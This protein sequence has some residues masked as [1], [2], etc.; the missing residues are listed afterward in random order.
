MR[1][2]RGTTITGLMAGTCPPLG[3][4]DWIHRIASQSQKRKTSCL[5]VFIRPNLAFNI[6]QLVNLIPK[7]S[8]VLLHLLLL[9]QSAPTDFIKNKLVPLENKETFVF[10]L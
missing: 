5:Y 7:G 3:T 8:L 6:M 10:P 4:M 9:L 2:G 1:T